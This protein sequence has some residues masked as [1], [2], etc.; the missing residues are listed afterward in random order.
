QVKR[1]QSPSEISAQ[2]SHA[3]NYRQLAEKHAAN[4]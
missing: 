2:R 4:N 3:L 1:Q